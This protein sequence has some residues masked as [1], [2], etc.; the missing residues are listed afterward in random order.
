MG[1]VK[2]HDAIFSSSIIEEDLIVRWIWICFL[3]ACDRN[4]NV[5][6]TEPALARKANVTLK[7][8]A[9]TN[10]VRRGEY[11]NTNPERALQAIEAGVRSAE[12]HR[13]YHLESHPMNDGYWLNIYR[14]VPNL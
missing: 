12:F 4:G 9:I 10:F 3:A 1:F 14:L 2:I 11:R 6:G 8:G 7:D 13:L 5:H